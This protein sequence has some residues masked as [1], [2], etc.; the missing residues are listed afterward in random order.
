MR[1]RGGK[2]CKAFTIYRIEQ[3]NIH[4]KDS[5]TRKYTMQNKILQRNSK[6]SEKRLQHENALKKENENI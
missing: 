5:K 2:Q 4:I 1:V 3:V 6:L